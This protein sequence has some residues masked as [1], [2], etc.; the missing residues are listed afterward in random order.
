[1]ADKKEFPVHVAII[2]D[3]NGRWAKKRG[4]ER[5]YGHQVG[6]ANVK[7]IV[8]EA[9]K[10]GIKILTL[11]AFSTENWKRP[12]YEVNFLMRLFKSYLMDQLMELMKENVQVHIVGDVKGLSQSLQEKIAECEAKTAANTGL[13]LNVAINYGG[14]AELV[15]AVKEI[16]G[17]VKNGKMSVKDIREETIQNHLYPSTTTDV[18]LLIRPGG[19]K[20]I[21]NFLLWQN[22]YAELYFSP[23]LWPDFTKEELQKAVDWY[24]GRD[25][26]FGGLTEASE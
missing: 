2:L 25:R 23:V 9:S 19:E 20:R 7:T 8:G 14:R 26:R 22:S 17:D 12:A 21:S 1:M 6:L 3:G 5:T 11:Y 24:C 18:D 15:K 4:R 16:A 13:V 10:M